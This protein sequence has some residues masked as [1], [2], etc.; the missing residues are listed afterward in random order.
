MGSEGLGGQDNPLG[1]LLQGLGGGAGSGGL[2]GLAEMA[3]G[4]FGQ[5]KGSVQSGNPL[6]I[7]GLAALAGALLGGGGGAAQGRDRRRRARPAR[8]ARHAG[9]A[10]PAAA[11]DADRCDRPGPRSSSRPEGTAERERGTGAR[12]T[13]AAHRARDDQ[14]GEGRRPDRWPGGRAHLRQARGGRLG[15]RKHAPFWRQEMQKPIDSDAI[16]RQATSPE[17]AVQVYAASLLAI[18]VDTAAERAYLRDLA[19]RLGLD[20]NA[21]SPCPPGAGSRCARLIDRYEGRARDGR[22]RVG[23]SRRCLTLAGVRPADGQ[24]IVHLR[25]AV[26]QPAGT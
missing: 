13:R 15:S 1:Q 25:L 22:I 26:K 17:L 8:H 21:V 3:Q 4:M 9:A 18:E 20:A 23:R 19:A 7:G 12:A 16:A 5:A 2:G 11:I 24:S 6:A 14:C 10:G